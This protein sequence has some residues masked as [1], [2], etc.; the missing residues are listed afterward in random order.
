MQERKN[1]DELEDMA[2]VW[3][4]GIRNQKFA[5]SERRAGGSEGDVTSN[6]ICGLPLER[7]SESRFENGKR[8]P[9]EVRAA[10]TSLKDR[11]GR[12]KGEEGDRGGSE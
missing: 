5:C 7:E 3:L 6:G 2:A 11:A 10:R 8:D 4:A 1:I 9:L 12:G